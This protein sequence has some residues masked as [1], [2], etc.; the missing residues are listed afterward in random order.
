MAFQKKPKKE[1]PPWK[2]DL[3]AHHQSKPSKVDRGEFPRKV[4]QELIA[5]AGGLCQVCRSAPDT[6][7]HHVVPRGRGGR[8][9]K[10]NGLRCCWPCHDR[11]QTDESQLRCWIDQYQYRYGSYFWYDELDWGE[12]NRK[13]AVEAAAALAERQRMD[14]LAPIV[15]LLSTAA[16]RRLNPKEIR[17]LDTLGPREMMIFTNLIKDVIGTLLAESK[18]FG[19]GHFDD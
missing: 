14:A 9:V 15:A 4:I 13:L 5:E 8:G 7:T 16:G 11:I 12:H 3:F 6:T 18:P 19:Y 10:T 17:L 1:L 2:K